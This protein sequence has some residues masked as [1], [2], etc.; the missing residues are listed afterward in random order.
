MIISYNIITLQATYIIDYILL[1]TY[2]YFALHILQKLN[3]KIERKLSL[4]S[5]FLLQL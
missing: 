4:K 3:P 5:V 1:F 2:I